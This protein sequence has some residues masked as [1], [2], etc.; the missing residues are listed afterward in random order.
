MNLFII[1]HGESTWNSKGIIQ[2]QRDPHLSARGKKQAEELAKYLKS[3]KIEKIFSS[4][5]KRAWQT[6]SIIGRKLNLPI[7][8]VAQL[9][10]VGLGFWQGKKIKGLDKKHKKLYNEWIKSPSK[11]NVPGAEKIQ[12]FR[13]RVG[14][15]FK[16]I[17]AKCK[18]G[19]NIAVVT[20]GGVICAYL[21]YVLKADID[22]LLISMRLDN[23]GITRIEIFE[24]KYFWVRGINSTAHLRNDGAGRTIKL[25]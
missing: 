23:A 5:L 4:D 1:R 17:V 9:Q 10:E 6:S 11:V 12:V 25:L 21:S 13:N 15:A 22:R 24:K 8:K 16:T 14:Q 2:G 18:K 3:C 19:E 20:H 7:V